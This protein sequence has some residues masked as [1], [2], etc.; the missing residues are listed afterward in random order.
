MASISQLSVWHL[1]AQLTD[2]KKPTH[3]SAPAYVEALMTW[4]QSILDDEKHFPQKIGPSRTSAPCP[5]SL[6]T[7][8]RISHPA[9]TPR[10][11]LPVDIPEHGQDD[12][13]SA[14]PR[15]RAHLPLA[16]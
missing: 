1:V 8:F 16:L 13:P 14:L 11:A 15:L 6:P 7:T 2:S 4:T 9:L 3:L 12:P 10:R 5:L